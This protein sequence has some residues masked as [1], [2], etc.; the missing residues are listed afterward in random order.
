[1][2]KSSNWFEKDLRIKCQKPYPAR[3]FQE[4]SNYFQIIARSASKTG[5]S[6]NTCSLLVGK[7]I[8][9]EHSAL[10][11]YIG[12]FIIKP[13]QSLPSQH[14]L[15]MRSKGMWNGGILWMERADFC[16]AFPST[17]LAVSWSSILLTNLSRRLDLTLVTMEPS[18]TVVCEPIMTSSTPC[19]A[20]SI[21]KIDTIQAWSKAQWKN[22]KM[23]SC[24]RPVDSCGYQGHLQQTILSIIC[25][26]VP[27][28]SGN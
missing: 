20:E 13:W 6:I 1:M 3:I 2:K 25:H 9:V 18:G 17:M 23:S 21:L 22:L 26:T 27:V 4:R 16:T 10:I 24:Q 8:R 11:T 15:L 12:T 19:D 28:G 5:F 14:S 7:Q